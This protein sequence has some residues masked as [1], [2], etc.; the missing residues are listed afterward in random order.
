MANKTFSMRNHGLSENNI[1]TLR[2]DCPDP[3][4]TTIS[5]PKDLI[6]LSLEEMISLREVLDSNISSRNEDKVKGFLS[7]LK[8][9]AK[10][11]NV[12]GYIDTEKV[13]VYEN[14]DGYTENPSNL[15]IDG[16]KINTLRINYYDSY[17]NYSEEKRVSV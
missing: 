7:E 5:S 13:E 10:R 11:Y 9:L 15:Y 12:S 16:K 8:R 6:N 2:Y 17:A 1:F 14:E 3:S 4:I